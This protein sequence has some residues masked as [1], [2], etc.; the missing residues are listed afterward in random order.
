MPQNLIEDSHI[1]NE[2]TNLNASSGR[3]LHKWMIT[4]RGNLRCLRKNERKDGNQNKNDNHNQ[5]LPEPLSHIIL[6][7]EI[8][9]VVKKM[10]TKKQTYA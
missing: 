7:T 1:R 4:S 6:H 8:K 10:K 2:D 9:S 3:F 5:V